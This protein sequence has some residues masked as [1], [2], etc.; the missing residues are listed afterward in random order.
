MNIQTL[1]ETH[2]DEIYRYVW[3]QCFDDQVAQD[4]VQDSFLKAMHAWP[5]L[6]DHHNL[7]A[8]L[9]RIAANT[10][11]DYWRRDN[12]Q[13][14]VA[15]DER[16]ASV[17]SIEANYEQREALTTLAAAIARLPEKQRHCLLLARYQELPYEDIAA[18]LDIS[19]DAARANV[20]Q[21]TK[22]L[23]E[24]MMEVVE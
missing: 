2:H 24:W 8:W 23:R 20:Y 14:Q 4:I 7:R 3:R 18:V 1:F 15:L 13:P 6:K 11:R 9:Y 5:D 16:L 12:R 21:A 17:V 22:K 19:A 10:L